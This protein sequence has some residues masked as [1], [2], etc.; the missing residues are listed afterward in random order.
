MDHDRDA[1]W[2]HVEQPSR[3]DDLKSLVHE[4]GGVDGHLLA[5]PPGGMLKRIGNGNAR[6]LLPRQSPKRAARGGKYYSVDVFATLSVKALEDGVVL[7]VDRQQPSASSP[8]G[9]NYQFPGHHQHFLIGER[10]ILAGFDRRIGGA[11]AKHAHHRAHH[12]LCRGI[13]GDRYGTLDAHANFGLARTKP[14][15]Q[16]ARGFLGGHRDELRPKALYLL[17]EQIDVS[18]SRQRDHLEPFFEATDH[19]ERSHADRASRA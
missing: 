4:G 3:F 18:T 9:V 6:K 1:L 7:A 17:G 10:D 13:G 12:K 15:A 5:H 2:F 14:A 19:V 11:Q 16:F 8:D